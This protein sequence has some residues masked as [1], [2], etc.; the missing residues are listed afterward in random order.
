M[1][2]VFLL[3]LLFSLACLPAAA[4]M[5]VTDAVVTTAVVDRMPVDSVQTFPVSAERLYFF[6]H[7]VGAPEETSVTHVW[8]LGEKEMARISLPVRSANWR[9]WSSKTLLPEWKGEWRVEVLDAEGN[10]LTEVNFSL[11]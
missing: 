11:F 7:I 3:T 1:K 8:Y 2:K 10:P 5:S 9:T 6:T 4:Q